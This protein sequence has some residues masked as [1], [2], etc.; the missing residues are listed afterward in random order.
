MGTKIAV[1]Q[2]SALSSS[3][4]AFAIA[5]RDDAKTNEALRAYHRQGLTNRKT[6]S[7]L[8]GVEHQIKIRYD[9]DMSFSASYQAF[10]QRGDCCPTHERPRSY[11]LTGYD[12]HPA[13][14]AK[15]AA[16][17]RPVS[18]RSGQQPRPT[19]HP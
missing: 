2:F 8:L 17:S 6:I 11:W 5:A 9:H 1:S 19:N 7:R 3:A 15:A 16:G 14:C 10:L 12:T 13:S 18:K 4:S